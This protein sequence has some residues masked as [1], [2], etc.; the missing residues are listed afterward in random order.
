VHGEATAQS[1]STSSQ[2]QSLSNQQN[3]TSGNQTINFPSSSGSRGFSIPGSN[4]LPPTLPTPSHFA[5]PVT[6]GNYG[7]LMGLLPYKNLFTLSDA[8]SLLE[9]RGKMR[10]FTTCYLPERSRKPSKQLRVFPEPK[11]KEQFSRH[12]EVIGIGNYKAMD[13]ES[14]SEHVLGMAVKEG[15]AIGADAMTFQEG[16]ALIQTARGFSIGLFNSFSYS[17]SPTGE[18]HGNISVGGVGYGRGETG[19]SSKPWLRVQFF[20]KVAAPSA[21]ALPGPPPAVPEPRS[22]EGPDD[23]EEALEKAKDPT[24]EE[25]FMGSHGMHPW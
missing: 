1:S 16:A 4:P 6:D 13:T 24:P 17:N 23:F 18:G 8:E 2:D 5:P 12:F 21:P 14:T 19:Y 10:V 22:G 7:S 9:N 11:E 20:R 25:K 3:I 15:M